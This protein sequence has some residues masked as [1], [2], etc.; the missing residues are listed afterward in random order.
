MGVYQN[1]TEV[2]IT[3]TF[4]IETIPGDFT[5][6][7]PT[8]P[9]TVT[10]YL[11]NPLGVVTPYV[12]GIA[13]E[14]TNPSV[15]VYVLATGALNIGGVWTY[16]AEGS[17]DV[18]AV[19]EGEF[20]I[21]PSS[22]LTP[23]QAEPTAGPC[24]VWCDPQDVVA[25]CAGE[26]SSDTSFLEDACVAATELLYA[27]SGRQFTGQCNQTARPCTD[28][29]GCWPYN[30][31]PGLSY[32]APQY[33]A[34]TSGWGSWGFWGSGWGWGGDSCGCNAI[35]RALLPGYPVTAITEVKIDGDV[36]DSDEY[37]LDGN[38]WLTRLGDTDGTPN[39]WPGCQN[40]AL[41]DT[42]VGTWSVS[43]AHGIAV[44]ELGHQAAMQLA[45]DIYKACA[46][47]DCASPSNTIQKTRAGVTVQ[48]APFVSWGRRSGQWVTGLTLVDMFLAAYN[49]SGVKRRPTIW[50]PDGP[51]Y[52]RIVGV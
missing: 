19:C 40:L 23:V 48:M 13:T 12:F 38:R 46:G 25:C 28:G 18:V 51:A 9:T 36:I 14:I 15:G 21:L 47:E 16:R 17:G 33:P 22:V 20:T 27:L 3:E 32:G 29:C 39:F 49:P 10:F 30:L 35:S 50:S 4:G 34:G 6:F 44:P 41:P 2:L 43:Y 42:E 8:D 52:A 24:Q 7:V 11:R 5:T 1:G 26:F 31:M 37:R 45:C